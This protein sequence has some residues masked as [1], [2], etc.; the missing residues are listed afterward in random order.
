M[1]M[2]KNPLLLL[3]LKSVGAIYLALSATSLL[4]VF[5]STISF[6]IIQVTLELFEFDFEEIGVV[7][8]GFFLILMLLL[9]TFIYFLTPI[10]LILGIFCGI[11]ICA[12]LYV[13]YFAKKINIKISSIISGFTVGFLGSLNIFILGISNNTST[14][15]FSWENVSSINFTVTS[16]DLTDWV[17]YWAISML[18]LWISFNF[19]SGIQIG[20]VLAKSMLLKD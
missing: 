10:N 20:K 3:P 7:I 16:S 15:K 2:L 5:I 8:I 17:F 14:K 4:M 9:A 11:I 19:Y 13:Q 18:L 6:A 1:K 12:V